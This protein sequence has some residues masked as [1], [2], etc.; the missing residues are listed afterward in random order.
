MKNAIVA[1]LLCVAIFFFAGFYIGRMIA[2]QPEENTV[3][4]I[5]PATMVVTGTDFVSDT[6]TLEDSTG[7]LWAFHGV[8]DWQ[9]GDVASVLMETNNT[10][11]IR[12]DR[13]LNVRYSAWTLKGE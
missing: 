13:I 4:I 2:P 8:E 12:D 7:N 10:A 9:V 5:Y 11:E 6:V 1:I 3:E